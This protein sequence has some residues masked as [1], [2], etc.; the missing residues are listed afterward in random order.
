MSDLDATQ[1]PPDT[2]ATITPTPDHDMDDHSGNEEEA[3]D[4]SPSNTPAPST[5]TS[6]SLSANGFKFP[7]SRIRRLI[8][9]DPQVTTISSEAV[10]Y[11][12]V[13]TELF[14]EYLAQQANLFATR[15]KRKTLLYKDVSRS[16]AMDKRMEFLGEIVPEQILF[17][18]AVELQQQRE[19]PKV[20]DDDEPMEP[21]ASNA[22]STDQL[23]SIQAFVDSSNN[24]M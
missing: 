15:E 23:P 5:S 17:S 8:K 6:D 21:V 3:T 7:A 9:L 18:K 14:C 24:S 10:N 19:K 13:A 4:I 11:V 1:L 2:T 22:A 12:S 20:V 16:V